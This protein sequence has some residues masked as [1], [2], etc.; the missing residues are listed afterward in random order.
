MLTLNE[1]LLKAS[2]R[3]PDEAT[4][5]LK[6]LGEEGSMN[7]EGLSLTASVKRA[8]LDHILL[9]LYAL[10]LVE[11][12]TEGKSKICTLTKLGDDFLELVEQ[13]G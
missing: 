11:V 3:L 1:Y 6:V 8:V 12:E 4:R 9:Q 7:K 13:A 2:N 10:G 5:V